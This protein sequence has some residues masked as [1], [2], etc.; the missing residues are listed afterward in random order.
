MKNSIWVTTSFEGLHKYK[1][2]PLEV[3]YLSTL[4]RHIFHVKVFIEVFNNDRDIEFIQFKKSV[5][6]SIPY[7]TTEKSCEMIADAIYWKLT[8]EYPCR[9]III[10]VSE[11]G[12]NGCRK[13]YEKKE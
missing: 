2:A 11:D 5:E 6:K 13:E 9:D 4:H 12:E 7:D 1:D 10:E 3:S 8:T